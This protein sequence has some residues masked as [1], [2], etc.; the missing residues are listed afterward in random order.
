M[1]N[2][3]TFEGMNYSLGNQLKDGI[4]S[5]VS[6]GLSIPVFNGWQV[7]TNVKNAILNLQNYEYQLQLIENNLYKEI[8]QAYTDALESLKKYIASAK[9]VKS[10]WLYVTPKIDMNW[11]N[12]FC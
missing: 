11:G 8:Q 10:M 5:Y 6:L 7:Q 4:N 2:P 1:F 3:D 9:A 12:K